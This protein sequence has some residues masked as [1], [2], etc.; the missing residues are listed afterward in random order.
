MAESK[1][2]KKADRCRKS[3][4]NLRYR[5]EHRHEK[6]HIRRINRHLGRYGTG[7]KA[8]SDALQRYKYAAGIR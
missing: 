5:N 8:A 2:S 7:D 3:T 1:K 4:Q 6:S